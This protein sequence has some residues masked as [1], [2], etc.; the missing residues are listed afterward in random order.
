VAWFV[1][2]AFGL[3][4][5]WLVPLV[6]D[7]QVVSAGVGWPTHFPALL[8]PLLAAFVM[9]ARQLGRRGGL[10]LL[11]R[12]VRVDVPVRW[13]L[14]A[15]S[16]LLLLLLVLLVERISG[17]ALPAA[18]QFAIFSGIPSG[19]GPLGVAGA[20]LVM[21]FG[22]ETGWRGYALPRLQQR[23]SPLVA[24]VVLAAIWVLWHAP[25]FLL[26]DTYRSFTVAM[27]AAWIFGLCCGAVVLSWLYNRSGGS[28]LLVAVW[29]AT[30][31]VISGTDA[32]TGLL[33]AASTTLVAALAITL[34]VL[35]IRAARRGKAS[36][37]G[38]VGFAAVSRG[39]DD[40]A[41]GDL[42]P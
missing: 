30:Y 16:P 9:T 14:F 38:P 6:V 5:A 20:I 10:D 27:L 2:L 31:N 18:G 22:E 12:M 15:V 7:G 26:V 34:V 35:E 21:S 4:W 23:H 24:T 33:A 39:G 32:A 41:G 1:A 42:R 40:L 37:L 29:H 3:S 11:H 19:W 13:W 17:Q 28:I 36:V 8:G 25:L